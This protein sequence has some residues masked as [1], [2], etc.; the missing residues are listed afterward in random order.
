MATALSHCPVGSAIHLPQAGIQ[1]AYRLSHCTLSVLGL[2]ILRCL[3]TSDKTY[4]FQLRL[5]CL[6]RIITCFNILS[7]RIKTY[8]SNNLFIQATFSVQFATARVRLAHHGLHGAEEETGGERLA[9]K[10]TRRKAKVTLY[11]K[12]GLSISAISILEL[13]WDCLKMDEMHF[14]HMGR[15]IQFLSY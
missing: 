15:P 5:G 9:F 1:G 3:P 10:L 7:I 2:L 13:N 12:V 11:L 8:V 14:C 4:K 6:V